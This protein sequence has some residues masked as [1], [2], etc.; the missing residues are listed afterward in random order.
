MFETLA[1]PYLHCDQYD[2]DIPMKVAIDSGNVEAVKIAFDHTTNNSLS[3]SE[4]NSLLSRAIY[5][6]R[7]GVAE[8]LITH[9]RGNLA[10]I[11]TTSNSRNAIVEAITKNRVDMVHFLLDHG[12]Y[13]LTKDKELLR[14]AANANNNAIATLL[15]DHGAPPVLYKKIDPLMRRLI[16]YYKNEINEYQI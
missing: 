8:Y 15:L 7:V 4:R 6:G 1:K 11:Y 16:A 3:N 12:I 10:E 2:H 14:I 13:D 5:E 9:Q